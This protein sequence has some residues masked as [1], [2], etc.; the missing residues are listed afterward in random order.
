[1]IELNNVCFT[2]SGER[3][4][5]GLH[6]INLT[7]RSGEVVL[8]CGSSGCGKTTLTRL[9]NGLIPHYYEG[10]LTGSVTVN[11][12][13]VSD[14]PLYA[15]AQT[16]GSVFQNPRSQFFNVD[17]TSE[18]AF[19]CENIGL[20]E[21]EVLQRVNSTVEN[22]SLEHLLGR[23]IFQLSGGEKQKIACGSVSALSPDVFVLDEPTSNM[24]MDGIE[25]LKKVIGFWKSQKKT[26]IIAEHRLH[27]LSEFCDRVIYMEDGKI[28]EEYN[29]ADFFKQPVDFYRQR[30]LR[31]LYLDNCMKEP[32]EQKECFCLENF[33][34]K[35]AK[36]NL[37]L[38]IPKA[39]LPVGGVIAVIGKNGAGKTTLVR[40][41]CG[42]LKKDS[43]ILKSNGK[44]LKSKKRLSSCYLV[45]QDV[46]HQL[47]TESV[48]DEVLLSMKQEDVAKAEKILESLDLLS[49]KDLHPMSLSGG[50]KQRVAIASAMAS[51]R[52][53]IVFDEPTSGLDYSHMLQV[54]DN[55]RKLR[56]QHKT[57]LIVTHDP[58]LIDACCSDV[59]HIEK[60]CV[61]E[62]YHLDKEGKRKLK[63]FFKTGR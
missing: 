31:T 19:A 58:E 63:E 43:G 49:F 48:L 47:F 36:S 39:K 7:I 30:G 41:I 13:L 35:Y 50:Q 42:L 37:V 1:M 32:S 55:I 3:P 59:L 57:V 56:E 33:R 4:D 44:C 23:S 46:N 9:I 26:I 5:A 8:L 16:V 38:D 52:E 21:D 6:N 14:T 45:M 17:T 61:K 27:F 62:I 24:D 40:S 10:T 20:P 28:S 34:Y 18:L 53:F 11:G 12:Q 60:G 51:E 15:M 25:A 29:G 22:L 54:A 2:Y